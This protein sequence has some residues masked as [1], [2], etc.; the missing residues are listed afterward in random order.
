MLSN[1][2][3]DSFKKTNK[4]IVQHDTRNKISLFGSGVTLS[5]NGFGCSSWHHPQRPI[6]NVLLLKIHL[7]NLGVILT[8][9]LFTVITLCEHLSISRSTL[10]RLIKNGEIEPV[11]IGSLTRFTE[12]EVNRYITRQQKQARRNE[13][14]F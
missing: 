14:G 7:L 3:S 10:F 1:L 11:R 6:K 8:H 5:H 4:H 13:V 12:N 9:P 2:L